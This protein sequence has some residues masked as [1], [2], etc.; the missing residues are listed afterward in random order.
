MGDLSSWRFCLAVF[1]IYQIAYSHGY[2][3]AGFAERS[4]RLAWCLSAIEQAYADRA[5]GEW[6]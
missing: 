4:G 1:L 2:L 6:R 3:T 5:A